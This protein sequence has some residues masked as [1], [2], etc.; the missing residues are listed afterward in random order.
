MPSQRAH[1]D[2]TRQWSES[3]IRS[4]GKAY[5]LWFHT[6][7]GHCSSDKQN[8]PPSHHPPRWDLSTWPELAGRKNSTNNTWHRFG[9]Q[10]SAHLW[11]QGPPAPFPWWHKGWERRTTLE[12]ILSPR[13]GQVEAAL[14]LTGPALDLYFESNRGRLFLCK[15]SI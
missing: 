6:G 14:D 13:E 10:H 1:G 7:S 3:K 9:F 4:N 5:K 12:V 2:H 11:A 15:W 8:P